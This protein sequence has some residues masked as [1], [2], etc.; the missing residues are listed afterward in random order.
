MKVVFDTDILVYALS[1]DDKRHRAQ[2]V[3]AAGGTV[4]VQV[5]NELVQVPRR[6]MPGAARCLPSV[7]RM[8]ADGQADRAGAVVGSAVELMTA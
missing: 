1:V 8:G 7:C 4:S 5:L 6:W 2:E 3:L